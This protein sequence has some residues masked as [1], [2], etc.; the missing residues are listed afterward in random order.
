MMRLTAMAPTLLKNMANPFG[1]RT[2]HKVDVTAVIMARNCQLS[3]H[4][5]PLK[6]SAV[7][8]PKIPA[9]KNKNKQM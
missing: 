5:T 1:N 2:K 7:N 8:I 3:D 9:V 4:K 6:P